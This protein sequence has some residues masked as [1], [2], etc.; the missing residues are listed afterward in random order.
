MLLICV[1]YPCHTS[2]LPAMHWYRPLLT[3]LLLCLVH[4]QKKVGTEER[5]MSKNYI[6]LIIGARKALTC[7]MKSM[8]PSPDLGTPCSGQ[9]VNWNWRIVRDWPSRASVT[10]QEKVVHQEIRK[11]YCALFWALRRDLKTICFR[12]CPNI[13][14][15][16]YRVA[17]GAR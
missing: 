5:S 17:S 16:H 14:F 13:L 3:K 4:L 8:K 10:W 9:S 12:Y 1:W 2:S 15:P 6:K 11:S 7:P